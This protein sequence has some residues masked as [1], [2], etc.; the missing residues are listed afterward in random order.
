VGA[1][2]AP[3]RVGCE[4]TASCHDEGVCCASVQF[5]GFDAAGF[6]DGSKFDSS[7]N[8]FA[9]TYACE[10]RCTFPEFQVCLNTSDCQNG[11]VC[12]NVSPPGQNPVLTCVPPD[13]GFL[14]P[15]AGTA[16]ASSAEEGGPPDAAP[17]SDD[18]SDGGGDAPGGG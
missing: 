6:A 15:D 16:D 14:V 8:G 18:A 10:S 11:E 9:L 5:P 17:A 2:E 4:N 12:T 1:C 3:F 7:G 13:A